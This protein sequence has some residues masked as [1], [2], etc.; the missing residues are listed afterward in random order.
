MATVYKTRIVRIGDSLGIRLPRLLLD[1]VGLKEYVEIAARPGQLIIRS[2]PPRHNWEEQFRRMALHGD[3]KLLDDS[4][5]T[6]C[7][8]EGTL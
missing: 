3:D 4:L 8:K 7:D 1:Q 5:L 6:R 2:R